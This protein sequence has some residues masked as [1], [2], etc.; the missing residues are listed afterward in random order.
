MHFTTET[1]SETVTDGVREQIFLLG[2]LPGVLWTPVTG[3]ARPLILLGHGGGQHKKAPGVLAHAHHYVHEL[4]AAV[5]CVDAPGHGDRPTHPE[6][7]RIA[8]ENAARVEAGEPRLPLIAAF[9]ALVAQQTVP[10]WQ[11]IVDALQ[12]RIGDGPVGYGGVSL[13]CGLGIPFVAA[14]S[15][16]RAAL[17]GCGSALASAA[18]AARITVP[19]Q[20]LA[21]WDDEFI[22]REQSLDLYNAFGSAEKTLH[23][24]PGAH[25]AIPAHEI[26]AA[27]AFFRRHLL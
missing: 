17:L 21:Q 26:D 20:Y 12:D 16:V 18:D 1:V 4:G 23:V 22:T 27:A 2:D 10:E 7:N 6:F 25:G 5:A 3:A 24:N 19:V 13:G 14:E 15:R 8:T 9:Q 11:L